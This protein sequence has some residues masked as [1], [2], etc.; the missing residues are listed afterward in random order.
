MAGILLLA[1][2]IESSFATTTI[3]RKLLI[4]AD[5]MSAEKGL[6]CMFIGSEKFNRPCIRFQVLEKSRGTP[7][8]VIRS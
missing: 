8:E 6:Q 4:D 1:F 7:H 2:A 3:Q 5:A